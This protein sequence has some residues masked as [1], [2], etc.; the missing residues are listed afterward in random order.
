MEESFMLD[1]KEDQLLSEEA[2]DEVSGGGLKGNL[3]YYY[4]Q[5]GDTFWKIAV[6][7]N[8]SM[9]DLGRLNNIYPPYLIRVQQELIVPKVK[10]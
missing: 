10:Y 3:E 9:E 5:P 4:V 8:I 1:N 2:L 7:H 6:T